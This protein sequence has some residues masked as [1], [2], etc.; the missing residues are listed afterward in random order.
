MINIKKI[1]TH[2]LLILFVNISFASSYMGSYDKSTLTEFKVTHNSNG[3]ILKSTGE[4]YKWTGMGV[5]T[6]T[7]A[8]E[9]APKLKPVT[10]HLGKSYDA[11]SPDY[12][13]GSWEQ[14]NGGFLVVFE[15][16]TFAFGR[17]ELSIN[18]EGSPSDGGRKSWIVII[19]GSKDSVTAKNLFENYR[20]HKKI[21]TIVDGS[22]NQQ[23]IYPLFAKSDT[24]EG[25]NS[26]FWITIVAESIH[27]EVAATIASYYN[28]IGKGAYI[29]A[30]EN[31]NPIDLRVVSIEEIRCFIP[32]YDDKGNKRGGFWDQPTSLSIDNDYV[33]ELPPYDKERAILI[34]FIYQPIIT[35]LPIAGYRTK[36]NTHCT[37]RDSITIE[38]RHVT[39]IEIKGVVLTCGDK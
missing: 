26:G 35:Q 7:E 25:L 2:L 32:L 20:K 21:S 12:G 33:G 17:Q 27:K 30:V 18:V 4:Q 16:E 34:P 28:K 29:R 14:N 3:V 15:N 24:I 13:K 37:F 5:H 19:H 39:N 22:R 6:S 38:K 11:W 36:N 9:G 31:H 23:E 10:L 8:I 1:I